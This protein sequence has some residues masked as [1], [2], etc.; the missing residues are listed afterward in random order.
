MHSRTAHEGQ[1]LVLKDD[2]C[3]VCL[4]SEMNAVVCPYSPPGLCGTRGQNQREGGHEYGYCMIM[5]SA[6]GLRRA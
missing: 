4:M 2:E 1:A 6:D 5:D 3:T